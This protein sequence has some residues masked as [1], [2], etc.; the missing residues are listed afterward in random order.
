M[1][2]NRRQHAL[3]LALEPGLVADDVHVHGPKPRVAHTVVL[4]GGFLGSF[5]AGSIVL[6]RVVL[7]CSCRVQA[8][9]A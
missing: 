9:R 5:C 1:G 4:C 6:E 2:T 8:Q 3:D 7:L